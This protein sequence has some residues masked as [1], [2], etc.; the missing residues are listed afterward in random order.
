[1]FL[2]IFN[3]NARQA[4]YQKANNHALPLLIKTTPVLER[5]FFPLVSP[6]SQTGG[7]GG[8]SI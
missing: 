4:H 3:I 7:G 5:N 2:S 1:M 8:I 6:F